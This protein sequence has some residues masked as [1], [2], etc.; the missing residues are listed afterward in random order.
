[1][2]W[3][4]TVGSE[5]GQDKSMGLCVDRVDAGNRGGGGV[6]TP[7]GRMWGGREGGVGDVR[8]PSPGSATKRKGGICHGEVNNKKRVWLSV[9]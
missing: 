3:E 4:T 2:V 8:K 1:V 6:D 7:M 5:Q 9:H